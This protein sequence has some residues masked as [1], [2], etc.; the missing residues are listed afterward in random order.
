[1]ETPVETPVRTNRAPSNASDFVQLWRPE[2]VDETGQVTGQ[3]T[4]QVGSEK[5]ELSAEVQ[6]LLHATTGAQAVLV[7]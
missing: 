1:V 5:E 4:E 7:G 2:P 6:R 3:V